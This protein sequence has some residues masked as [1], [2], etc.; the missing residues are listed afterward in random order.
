MIS[1]FFKQ[2]ADLKAALSGPASVEEK[3]AHIQPMLRDRDVEREFWN[4]L[5]DEHWVGVLKQAGVFDT[6]P[7]P[8][9]VEGGTRFPSWGASK[10]LAR[11]ASR[12]PSEVAA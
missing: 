9:T 3:F 12:V 5:D 11:V 6:P 1:R 2:L 7:Q 8:E 10:Y 4:L